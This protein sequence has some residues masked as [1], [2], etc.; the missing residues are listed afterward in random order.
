[1]AQEM[2]T[3]DAQAPREAGSPNG[4][5]A[6]VGALAGAGVGG[7]LTYRLE[8]TNLIRSALENAEHVPEALRDAVTKATRETG[9]HDVARILRTGKANIRHIDINKSAKGDIVCIVVH[10]GEREKFTI[11]L[12]DLPQSVLETLKSDKDARL[13]GNELTPFLKQL[14]TGLHQAIMKS[15]A[16]KTVGNL[17]GHMSM[18]AKGM[19]VGT[20]AVGAV[21]GGSVLNAVFQGS[22]PASHAERVRTE[23]PRATLISAGQVPTV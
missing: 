15:E 16:M 14:E 11:H 8:R 1:M 18:G 4:L 19:I 10:H 6:P 20:T 17:F 5:L 7:A 23:Q 12:A 21:V 3:A 9:M 22:K 2:G 13:I